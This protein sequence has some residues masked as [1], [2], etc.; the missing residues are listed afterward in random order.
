VL[1]TVPAV[2]VKLAAVAPPASATEAGTVN[3]AVLF[4]TSA[5]ETP[6]VDAG[7]NKVT[8][9]L[10]VAPDAME[11]GEQDKFET[12]GAPAEVISIALMVGL[13]ATGIRDIVI[14]PPVTVRG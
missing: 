6:P 5:T 13:S 3:A 1:P 2:A 7:D 8:V 4:E 14:V 10:E 12:D 9:Q 11:F